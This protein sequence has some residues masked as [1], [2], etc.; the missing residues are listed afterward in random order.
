VAGSLGQRHTNGLL[1]RRRK[2]VALWS[3]LL[4][5]LAGVTAVGL[6]TGERAVDLSIEQ[7][8][9]LDRLESVL[10][11][12]TVVPQYALVV[13]QFDARGYVAGIGDFSTAN[14]QVL[15]VVETYTARVGSNVL[16]RDYLAALQRHAHD[17]SGDVDDLA[18]FPEAWRQASADPAF[19]QV[20]DNTMER[21]YFNPARA[22]SQSLGLT[23][24]LG[25]AIIY[26][27][28]IQHGNTDRADALP[29]LVDRAT[30]SVG[31]R[32][33]E[34][35]EREWL[36][37]FLKVREATLTNP[38]DPAHAEIWPSSVGR[39]EALATL[40]ARHHDDLAPPIDADPY[41]TDH[42]IDLRPVPEAPSIGQIATPPRPTATTPDQP[43]SGPRSKAPSRLATAPGSAST[44][45]APVAEAPTTPRTGIVVR[46]ASLA[47]GMSIGVRGGSTG[48]GAPI[49]AGADSNSPAQRWRVVNAH[50]GCYHLLNVGS[51]MALDNTNGTS[52]NGIQMQQYTS[53]WGNENQTWCF[54]QVGPD[55]Y[56]IRNLTSGFLLDLRDGGTSDGTA[57]QQWKA[58]PAKPD[59]NQTWRLFLAG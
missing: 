14:G 3:A 26:D 32:P 5:A 28:L 52:T 12:D 23:T 8:D 29:T 17:G 2:H 13:N 27:S 45:A 19:R 51:G 25:L 53:Y 24:A 50:A 18:G 4:V 41:G 48:V 11:H 7:R 46:I 59:S 30:A 38:T 21:L 49:V 43:P 39:V 15:E 54:Q 31:G 58:D 9:M 47:M 35:A 44:G 37:A 57:V 55:S 42:V 10:M 34:V 1:R 16:S 40:L 36:T 20:Q 33:G 56:S 6:H 22:T